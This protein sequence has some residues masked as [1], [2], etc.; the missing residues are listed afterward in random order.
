MVDVFALNRTNVEQEEQFLMK[1]TLEINYNLAVGPLGCW[2]VGLLGRRPS[3]SQPISPLFS[4][5]IWYLFISIYLSFLIRIY[6][7]RKLSHLTLNSFIYIYRSL[8]LLWMNCSFSF[9]T[10]FAFLLRFVRAFLL[11]F[12]VCATQIFDKT[13][14]NN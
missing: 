10:K 9:H 5:L 14:Q 7:S 6:L 1:S 13:P 8:F 12:V 2:A 11:L 3:V 4:Y